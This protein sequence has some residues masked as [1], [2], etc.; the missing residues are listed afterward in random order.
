MAF[1]TS[2]MDIAKAVSNGEARAV[3]IVTNA[4][5]EIARQ[6]ADLTCFV[7]VTAEKAL[8][9]ARA[10]DEKAARG[11][12][13]GALAGVPFAVKDLFDVKGEV[14]KAG[15]KMRECCGSSNA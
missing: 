8:E 7:S 12:K 13:L 5:E 4:L 9:A 10:I 3:D 15:A 6:D 1:S 11:E 2:A 14:T